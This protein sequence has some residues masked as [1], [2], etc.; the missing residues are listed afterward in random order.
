MP[1]ML[2]HIERVEQVRL[3][4]AFLSLLKATLRVDTAL[5]HQSTPLS[6]FST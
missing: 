4:G 6:T 3:L 1:P 5:C 2:F